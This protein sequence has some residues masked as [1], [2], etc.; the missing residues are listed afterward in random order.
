MLSRAEKKRIRDELITRVYNEAWR[1]RDIQGELTKETIRQYAP[2]PINARFRAC[3]LSLLTN[4]E[5]D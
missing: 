3:L 1:I 2:G 5:I 4:G